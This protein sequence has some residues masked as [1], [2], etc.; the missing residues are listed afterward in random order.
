MCNKIM[1]LKKKV[2][3]QDAELEVGILFCLENISFVLELPHL[4]F[5]F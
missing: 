3:T 5:F 2:G 1:S 4:F